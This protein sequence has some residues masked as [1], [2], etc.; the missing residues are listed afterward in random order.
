MGCRPG[1]LWWEIRLVQVYRFPT[2]L[3]VQYENCSS[4]V[5]LAA[6]RN[7]ANP[8]RYSALRRHFGWTRRG[9]GS[10]SRLEGSRSHGE[11]KSPLRIVARADQLRA[12]RGER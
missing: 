12:F 1:K 3:A 6:R 9:P 4:S 2:P 5:Y 7:H 8:L 11:A 10:V